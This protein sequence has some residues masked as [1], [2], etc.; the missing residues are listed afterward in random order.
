MAPGN[1][2]MNVPI[3]TGAQA[4]PWQI[5]IGIKMM[6]RMNGVDTTSYIL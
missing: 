1:E 6:R 2:G 4:T 3:P 5:H